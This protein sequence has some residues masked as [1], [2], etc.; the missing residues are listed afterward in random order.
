M[1]IRR[2]VDPHGHAGIRRRASSVG[3]R[4]GDHLGAIGED[5]AEDDGHDSETETVN[6]QTTENNREI[7]LSTRPYWIHDQGIK[8]GP[9]ETLSTQ[10]EGFWNELLE[11]YLYPIDED[12]AE[13]VCGTWVFRGWR[14]C[15]IRFFCRETN[16]RRFE[17]VAVRIFI[18]SSVKFV[19]DV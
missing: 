19:D 12:K 13:K 3:S 11:K 8:N 18:L 14:A 4:A 10:E 15:A 5:P 7:D 9:I 6:S 17:F 16:L 2:A 1:K